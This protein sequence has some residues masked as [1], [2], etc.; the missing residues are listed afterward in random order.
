MG[1]DG[2]E[3]DVQM[4]CEP[5][6]RL[7]SRIASLT[8]LQLVQHLHE[9]LGP[10]ALRV[11]VFPIR[12]MIKKKA[13]EVGLPPQQRGRVSVL[14]HARRPIV[15]NHDVQRGGIRQQ[16]QDFEMAVMKRRDRVGAVRC[17]GNALTVA[18]FVIER[19][20]DP[21][22]TTDPQSLVANHVGHTQ[23]VYV[24]S[25]PPSKVELAMVVR[26]FVVSANVD[27]QY[28]RSSLPRVIIIKVL[29]PITTPWAQP[30]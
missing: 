30:P 27:G 23:V 28:G 22:Q 10:Q 19:L 29:L 18:L 24:R 16:L 9:W 14:V 13:L 21:G 26:G 5:I 1:V 11:D 17:V 2:R 25:D 7:F 15:R 4:G 3:F 8:N 6:G 20:E 12:Q